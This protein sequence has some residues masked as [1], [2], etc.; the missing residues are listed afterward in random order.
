MSESSPPLLTLEPLLEAVQ[1]GI[2][3][4]GWAL[5]GIQKTTSLQFE[6]RWEGESTRSA[7]LFF[8]REGLPDWVS[9]DVFLDETSRG[10]KGNLALVMD[11]PELGELGSMEE[12]IEALSAVCKDSLPKGYA[13]PVSVR[14]RL[15]RPGTEPAKAESE[16]RLKLRIPKRAYEAGAGALSALASAS[17]TAFEAALQ[18]AEL[19]PFL[20]DD[21]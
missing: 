17:V 19:R 21:D 14:L 8:H 20:P 16:F 18:H 6:G 11:G 1:D 3:R 12:L 13:T 7:Y 2:E 15:P 5:S 4:T 10:L 9:L